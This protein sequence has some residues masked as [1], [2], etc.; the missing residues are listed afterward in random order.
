MSKG[1][2][3]IWLLFTDVIDH[4]HEGAIF[5][6]F[7]KQ[8][9]VLELVFDSTCKSWNFFGIV[10]IPAWPKGSQS[11]GKLNIVQLYGRPQP[12][13]HIY[14]HDII[15]EISLVPYTRALGNVNSC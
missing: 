3:F 10:V 14:N 2:K 7:L 8:E 11:N 13:S 12:S 1:R 15:I 6:H 9:S 5:C 4:F